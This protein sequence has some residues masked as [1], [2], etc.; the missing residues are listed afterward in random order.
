MS[1]CVW[2]WLVSP[3]A[4]SVPV[5]MLASLS[6]LSADTHPLCL[7]LPHLPPLHQT[8]QQHNRYA[9]LKKTSYKVVTEK[10]S[11]DAYSVTY[12]FPTAEILADFQ[13]CECFPR[14]VS[15]LHDV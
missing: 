4:P 10:L 15:V 1:A 5:H 3:V 12:Q 7:L 13:T 14:C 9:K 8:H 2:L 11:D 6:S